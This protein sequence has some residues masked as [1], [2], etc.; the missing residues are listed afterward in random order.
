MQRYVYMPL[1]LWLTPPSEHGK[2]VLSAH[3]V[4]AFGGG[5]FS[6]RCLS[7]RGGRL[8]RGG[9]RARVASSRA[10]YVSTMSA[11]ARMMDV[12]V[13]AM[14]RSRSS[15]PR[16]AAASTIAYSPDTW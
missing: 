4:A 9:Q 12:T 7:A 8:F 3:L 2:G 11:P 16:W 5:K 1:K 6:N 15:Q 13:S 14:A 10:Q